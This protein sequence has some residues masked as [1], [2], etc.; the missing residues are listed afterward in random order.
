MLILAPGTRPALAAP[1]SQAGDQLTPLLPFGVRVDG[2][3][4]GLMRDL[5]A[6]IIGPHAAQGA[7]DLVGRPAPVEQTADDAEQQPR[8]GEFE[9]VRIRT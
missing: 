6:R 9:R 3:V 2:G 1:L 5:S 7:S 8:G 4:N